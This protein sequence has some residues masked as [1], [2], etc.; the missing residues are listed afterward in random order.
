MATVKAPGA[1]QRWRGREQ[2]EIKRELHRLE[3]VVEMIAT[4][5]VKVREWISPRPASPNLVLDAQLT[6]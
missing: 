5:P 3:L 4:L 2:S 1:A 6:A